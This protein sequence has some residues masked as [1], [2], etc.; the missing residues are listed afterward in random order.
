MTA[1][2][3][4]PVAGAPSTAVES[5][6]DLA[7]ASGADN[8]RVV[9]RHVAG[10]RPADVSHS[11]VGATHWLR[12]AAIPAAVTHS[13]CESG[14]V[15]WRAHDRSQNR[16]GAPTR[17]ADCRGRAQF[18]GAARPRSVFARQFAAAVD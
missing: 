18:D 5:A 9:A 11:V 1:A 12:V 10:P 14:T 3:F 16:D 4:D 15:Q 6:I 8:P 2:G 13:T 7:G 17:G